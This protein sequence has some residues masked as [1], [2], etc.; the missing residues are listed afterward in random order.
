MGTNRRDSSS[1]L[2]N[3]FHDFVLEAS[4]S[5]LDEALRS[6]GEDPNGV[7]L[8]GQTAIENAL[9][10]CPGAVEG[11]AEIHQEAIDRVLKDGFSTLVK[12]LRRQADMSMEEL[13]ERA[14]VDLREIVRIEM[15]GE[16]VPEPR[17]VFQLEQIFDLPQRTLVLLSG[18]VVTHSE[19]FR[20][21]V[22]RFAA[23]SKGLDTLTRKQRKALHQFVRFLA[24]EAKARR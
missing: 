4:E 22:E 24:Q 17:T 23:K 14:A 10:E 19:E 1:S 11:T 15:D 6:E 3:A 8:R 5:E 7:Y 21:E 13:A 16:Y 12:L 9:R 18:S 20:E 2:L